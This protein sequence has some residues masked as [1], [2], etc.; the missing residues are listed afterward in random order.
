MQRH[1]RWTRSSLPCL[2]ARRSQIPCS[3]T[4][5]SHSRCTAGLGDAHNAHS[6]VG[7][8]RSHTRSK[9]RA[10]AMQ[11]QHAWGT[12]TCHQGPPYSPFTHVQVPTD[13]LRWY[14]GCTALL[15]YVSNCQ[16]GCAVF[17]LL[18]R[19]SARAAFLCTALIAVITA[20]NPVQSELSY[21]PRSAR[22]II[23]DGT[24]G[25]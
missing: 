24:K 4:Q 13:V 10:R 22:T 19:K 5:R 15:L 9:M 16:H 20:V 18:N 25:V 11:V 1:R 2:T 12:C 6:A 14:C 23:T 7:Q 3:S 17:L 8:F 21:P